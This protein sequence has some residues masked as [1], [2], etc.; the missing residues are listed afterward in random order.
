MD[1]NSANSAGCLSLRALRD[2]VNGCR[3][4]QHRRITVA[5]G[6]GFATPRE[7][8]WRML[9]RRKLRSIVFVPLML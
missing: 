9:R 7:A 5:L 3:R 2:E 1:L 8:F 4:G 6:A